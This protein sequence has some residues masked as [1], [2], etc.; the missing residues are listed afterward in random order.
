MYHARGGIFME[1]T[2]VCK[3][4]AQRFSTQEELMA[5]F[6]Q[7]HSVED[8]TGGEMTEIMH[9]LQEAFPFA[10][11]NVRKAKKE[12]TGLYTCNM[13]WEEENADFSFCIGQQEDLDYYTYDESE[14][15][16]VESAI[17]Y[18]QRFLDVKNE[19]FIKLPHLYPI[20]SLH[21]QQMY[22]GGYDHSDGI[23]FSF[24]TKPNGESITKTYRFEGV[25]GFVASF[26]G[27]FDD[28][29]EGELKEKV[30]YHSGGYSKYEVDYVDVHTILERAK[31]IKIQILEE[32]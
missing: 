11:V 28:L 14:F 21:I 23:T 5:H 3:I 29:F 19:V 31:R 6:L 20:E 4:D 16:T 2:F 13:V 7:H 12:K 24:Q 8:T 26:R 10:K 25:D 17:A 18:Y 32:K 15:D 22:E 9:Q 1:K 30:D 27:Y